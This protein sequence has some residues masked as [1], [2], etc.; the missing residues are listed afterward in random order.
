MTHRGGSIDQPAD[1]DSSDWERH[2][3]LQGDWHVFVRPVRPD[4]E[5]NIKSLLQHVTAEDLRL[6]F[7]AA[8][9]D[10]SHAFLAPLIHFDQAH[11]MAF[12]AFDEMTGGSLGVVRIHGAASQ[13]FGEYAVLLRSDLKGHG[14]GWAL[15]GLMIAY[16]KAM[17]LKQVRGQ[18]L[19]HNVAMLKM[20]R[21]FGF[22][23]RSDPQDRSLCDVT[24]DLATA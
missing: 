1:V 21:E 5:A 17:G 3:V 20:C 8:I 13:E 10:F 24:L 9:K 6:R 18:V 23:V 22:V 12:I 11:A 16:A 7:F 2:L 19:Q 15:M 14:L 4:D